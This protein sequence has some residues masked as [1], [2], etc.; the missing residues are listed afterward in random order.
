MDNERSLFNER[1]NFCILVFSL[2]DYIDTKI[3]EFLHFFLIIFNYF[4]CFFMKYISM[5]YKIPTLIDR[6]AK[7]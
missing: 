5:L 3:S 4:D 2:R 1:K 6:Y 7:T